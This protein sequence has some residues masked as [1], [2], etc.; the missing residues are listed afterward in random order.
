MV[1]GTHGWTES[2]QGS[3]DRSESMMRCVESKRRW[4]WAHTHT[5]MCAGQRES[6]L[7]KNTCFSIVVIQTVFVNVT[8]CL[9]KFDSRKK[10]GT[11]L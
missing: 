10:K 7:I 4:M 2:E 11:R 5:A 3:G 8:C 1:M 9:L 6:T